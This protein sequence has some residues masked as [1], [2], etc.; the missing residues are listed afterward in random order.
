[1]KELI[2]TCHSCSKEIFCL[3]GFFNGVVTDEK[4]IYCFECYATLKSNTDNPQMN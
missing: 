1:M 3:E 4:R 2:G